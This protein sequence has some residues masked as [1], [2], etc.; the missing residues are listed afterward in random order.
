MMRRK[1]FGHSVLTSNGACIKPCHQ[2]RKGFAKACLSRKLQNRH[3]LDIEIED[4]QTDGSASA[5]S[6]STRAGLRLSGAQAKQTA[7]FEKP[8]VATVY[9]ICNQNLRKIKPPNA[10]L[11]HEKKQNVTFFNLYFFLLGK[12]RKKCNFCCI[13]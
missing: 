7:C 5:L 6:E 12:G 9:K 10:K 3:G 13:F 1:R 2:S 4:F 11:H 8:R